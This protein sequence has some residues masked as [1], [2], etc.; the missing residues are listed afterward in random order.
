MA[1]MQEEKKKKFD[2]DEIDAS[3]QPE[4]FFV[5]V[6]L[7]CSLVSIGI[8][9]WMWSARTLLPQTVLV[10]HEFVFVTLL[11]LT[12][13][14]FLRYRQVLNAKKAAQ[15]AADERLKVFQ[16]AA[17]EQL[18]SSQSAAAAQ[19]DSIRNLIVQ[20]IHI[21]H[22]LMRKTKNAF[23]KEAG[24]VIYPHRFNY[25]KSNLNDLLYR[26]L[27]AVIS[28]IL[29]IL[30]KNLRF[31]EIKNEDLSISV[32]AVVTDEMAMAIIGGRKDAAAGGSGELKVI[33]LD[34]D[35]YTKTVH[36]EREVRRSA[37]TLNHNSD[38]V[39]IYF[40][41]KD[42]FISNDLTSMPDYENANRE[43]PRRYNATLVVPISYHDEQSESEPNVYGF[44]TVDSMN[45]GKHEDLF[46]DETRSI[47]SF[48]A[49][50]LALIFLYLEIYD[51]LP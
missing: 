18:K 19:L 13:F 50:L 1:E 24:S 41:K 47:L 2:I 30:E 28:E 35:H 9:W 38:F 34:R 16:A 4:R 49:E 17:D 15:L 25:R 27:N 12:G 42:F 46:T 3:H 6:A 11:I 26:S 14:F 32:K 10:H 36:L 44:L 29:R 20:Q 51:R 40:Q 39:K 22:V 23:Y 45:Q 21:Y 48:G 43:W 37:Y 5:G 7:A 31:R 33:T 8:S